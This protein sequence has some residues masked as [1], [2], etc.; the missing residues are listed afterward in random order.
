MVR[1]IVHDCSLPFRNAQ[2]IARSLQVAITVLFG[3]EYGGE[4][5]EAR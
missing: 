2:E 3:P 4:T 5:I 1:D